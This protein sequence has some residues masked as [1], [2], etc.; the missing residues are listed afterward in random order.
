MLIAT[1]FATV[2]LSYMYTY[3]ARLDPFTTI[4]TAA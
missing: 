3:I 4:F 2:R 1:K